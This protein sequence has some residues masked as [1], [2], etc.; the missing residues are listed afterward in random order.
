MPVQL[1]FR[2]LEEAAPGDAWREV[3][4]RGWPG[5]RAWYLRRGMGRG[6]TLVHSRAALTRHMPEFLPV[7][8]RLVD[9]AGADETAARFLSFWSPPRYLVHCSQAVMHGADGPLL[10]RNYDLDPRLN[11]STLYKTRWNNRTVVGMVEGMSGLADGMNDAGLAVSL[12]FGGRVES[13]Q[14]FG[15]PQIIRYLLETCADVS[16]AVDALRRLPCHMSY[17]LTLLDREG[18]W[19]TVMLAPDRP[20]IATDNRFA[21]N[22]QLGVEWPRHGRDSR[23]LERSEYLHSIL[24]DPELSQ[25]ALEAAFL[26][27]PLFSTGYARGFGT[28]YTTVYR[29]LC[30]TITLLWPDGCRCMWDMDAFG[31]RDFDVIYMADGSQVVASS[32]TTQSGAGSGWCGQACPGP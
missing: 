31:E 15:I 32:K 5:W 7:W 20:P 9:A 11:E 16:E 26:R 21:T 22:H 4:R 18:N 8:E 30:G 24:S 10:I 1:N 2:S 28:V 3:F 14:G 17:N 12:T 25:P 23:T 29:P 27:S 13:G 6:P 19:A